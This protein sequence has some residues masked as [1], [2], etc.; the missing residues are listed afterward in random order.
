MDQTVKYALDAEGIDTAEAIE[1]FSGY[2]D[3]FENFLMTFHKD[4]HMQQIRDAIANDD[5][6]AGYDASHTMKGTAGNL[7]MQKLFELYDEQAQAFRHNPARARSIMPE[8]E[9]EY[10]RI[11][12][13]IRIILGEK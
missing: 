7:S 4:V 11:T 3:L 2:E 12:G 9:D 10:A 13:V 6:A 1:R 8:I 5:D